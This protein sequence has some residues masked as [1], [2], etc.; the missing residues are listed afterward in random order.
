VGWHPAPIG[1]NSDLYFW[2]QFLEESWCRYVSHK[3]P[4]VVHLSSV[5]RK[6]WE[7]ARRVEELAAWWEKIQTAPQR[8]RLTRECLLSLHDRL[9]QEAFQSSFGAEIVREIERL[10]EA[11]TVS[12]RASTGLEP[13]VLGQ[14]LRFCT[15]GNAARHVLSG[16]WLPEVWGR[17]TL[18]S[19]ANVVLPLADPVATDLLLDLEVQPFLHDALHPVS[20]F[21]VSLNGTVVLRIYE[22]RPSVNRYT[23]HIP[24]ALCAGVPVL[25]LGFVAESPAR[26]VDLGMNADDRLLGLGLVT[27]KVSVADVAGS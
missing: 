1:I 12:A 4:E 5:P 7:P 3:W 20:A 24:Q 16:F 23:A 9:L 26:P 13:Y 15:N 21:S 25:V 27:L 22:A 2:L 18:G 8:E 14:Q 6:D 17:W 10:T 11:V 19:V